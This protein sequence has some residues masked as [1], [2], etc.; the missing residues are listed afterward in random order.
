MKKMTEMT[1]EIE[2]TGELNAPRAEN[3]FLKMSMMKVP[4]I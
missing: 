2:H 1:N 3:Q 4:C